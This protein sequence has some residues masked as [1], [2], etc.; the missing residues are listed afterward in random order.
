MQ[1]RYREA[2]AALD[3]VSILYEANEV[4]NARLLPHSSPGE[5]VSILYEANEVCNKTL[6]ICLTWLA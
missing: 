3:Q 4:C 2:E 1:R 5:S 6:A